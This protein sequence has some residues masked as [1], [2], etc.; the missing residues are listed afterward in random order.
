[1]LSK[2]KCVCR[3][4]AGGHCVIYLAILSVFP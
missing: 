2:E 1:G 3:C 4:V